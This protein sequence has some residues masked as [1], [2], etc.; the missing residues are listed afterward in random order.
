MIEFFQ[1]DAM[2]FRIKSPNYGT[3]S[4][5]VANATSRHSRSDVSLD[6]NRI[7]KALPHS[8]RSVNIETLPE[9]DIQTP[10]R[11]TATTLQQYV[12]P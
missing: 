3:N 12:H 1:H 7:M 9:S 10:L 4:V 8:P 6:R 5:N 2:F 11:F